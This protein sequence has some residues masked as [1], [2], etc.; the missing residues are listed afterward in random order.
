[1]CDMHDIY[2]VAASPIAVLPQMAQQ[3]CDS[4]YVTSQ[5]AQQFYEG[6]LSK[7]PPQLVHLSGCGMTVAYAEYGD[8]KSAHVV[9]FNHGIPGSRI[10]EGPWPLRDAVPSTTS[11]EC[12]H[13][14]P[15][16]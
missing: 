3:E 9:I 11:A 15:C 13:T 16:M 7:P 4:G 2:V 12:H 10:F 5:Y 1:M 6:A 8:P 14:L